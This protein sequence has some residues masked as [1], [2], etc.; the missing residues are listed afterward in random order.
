MKHYDDILHL[1][2][3]VSKKHRQMPIADRAAQFMPFAALTGYEAALTETARLTSP[4]IEPDDAQRELLNRQLCFLQ[5]LAAAADSAGAYPES[6]VSC[7]VSDS[8]ISP[9]PRTHAPP[10]AA[11]PNPR[12]PHR[13]SSLASPSPISARTQKKKAAFIAPSPGG[14]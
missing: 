7:V 14:F 3:P 1:P 2:H 9:S 5:S 12:V 8:D 6:R 10:R 4:R 11:S 13:R